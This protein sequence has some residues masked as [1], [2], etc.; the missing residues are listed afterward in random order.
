MIQQMS[1]NR[2]RAVN[3]IAESKISVPKCYDT[4]LGKT[5][6]VVSLVENWTLY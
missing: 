6:Y 4:V 5:L 1:Y 3:H 2:N